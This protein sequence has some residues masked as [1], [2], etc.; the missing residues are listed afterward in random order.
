MELD[1][2]DPAV[3]HKLESAT[4]EYIASCNAEIRQAAHALLQVIVMLV[5]CCC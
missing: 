1:E 3:W 4:D 2:I 5:H